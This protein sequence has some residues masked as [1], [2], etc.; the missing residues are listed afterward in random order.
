MTIFLTIVGLLIVLGIV[1]F[2]HELGHYLAARISGVRV[3][4]FSIGFR[5]ILRWKDRRGTEWRLGWVPFGGY[6]NIY[7][8]DMM[9][10]PKEYEALPKEKKK[11]HYLSVS[12]WRR[13]LIIA[14]GVI[15][16]F[17]LAFVIYF[18]IAWL[19]P[20]NVQLP[21]IGQVIQGSNAYAAGVRA[22]DTVVKIDGAKIANWG[23]LLIAKELA[24]RK[25]ADIILVRGENLVNVKMA[26]AERWGLVA[27]GAKTET[28]KNNIWQAGIAGARKTWKESKTIVI[29]I[30]QIIAGER[31]SKSLGSFIMIAQVSGQA[32]A[33]G[34]VALLSI[35]ALLSVNLGVI[36]LLP[37]PVL[38]GGY[39]LVLAVEG[40]TRRKLQGKAMEYVWIGGWVL[41]GLLFALTM[42][43]DIFRV[44][45]L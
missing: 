12:A 40:I 23:D 13:A 9:F 7:G 42:K 10:N 6:C 41:I 20:Q 26:P 30:K 18:G 11:G 38:D 3:E 4:A 5:P 34:F 25:T 24:G 31:S 36:N 29:V 16:N 8:Q 28:Q 2:V 27:D 22:G 15:M 1:V 35:I 45:G 37:L 19:R 33:A 17:A 21:V 14:G 44:L 43:N 39:L 32:L